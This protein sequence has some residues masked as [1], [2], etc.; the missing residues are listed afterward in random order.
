[1][2]YI[3]QVKKSYFDYS[4]DELA[5]FEQYEEARDYLFE[6]EDKKEINEYDLV[7]FEL[8]LGQRLS[9]SEN[10][11]RRVFVCTVYPKDNFNKVIL[12]EADDLKCD[13]GEKS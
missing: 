7:I 8:P 6:F 2:R 13:T 5:Y 4:H 1:M 9:F 12:F 11:Y 3:Y 10:N